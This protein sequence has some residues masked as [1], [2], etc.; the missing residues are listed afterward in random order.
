MTSNVSDFLNERTTATDYE[1]LSKIFG[2][3]S[4][5]NYFKGI[6]CP[7]LLNIVVLADYFNVSVDE[8]IGR[9]I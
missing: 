2:A 5:R 6:R 9:T 1:K 4:M 7:D 3:T 8:V